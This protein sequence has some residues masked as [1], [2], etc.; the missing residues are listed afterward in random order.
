MLPDCISSPGIGSR[1]W[2]TSRK[3]PK[4]GTMPRRRSTPKL[5]LEK[6][7][8]HSLF[9]RPSKVQVAHLGK[10]AAPGATV[11]DLFDALPDQLAARSLRNWRDSVVRAVR[12]DRPVIAALG[13]HVI[14]TG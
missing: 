13:G 8:T 4:G 6:L 11:A 2:A 10:P 5:D 9:D 12:E 7:N 1:S 3:T 14:K